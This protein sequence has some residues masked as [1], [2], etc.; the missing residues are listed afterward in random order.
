MLRSF[1]YRIYPNPP[2]AELM[3]KHIGSSRYIYNWGLGI[4][5]LA[6]T[7]GKVNFSRQDLQRELPRMKV[8]HP[9]MKEVNA[10]TLQASLFDLEDAYK[11]FFKGLAN[12]PKFKK[13]FISKQSF[14]IPQDVEVNFETKQV[15]IPKFKEPIKF[16]DA[17]L[18][19][20]KIKTC[21][22]KKS[23]S[24]K[25][26]ISILVEDGKELPAKQ[27]LLSKE[28][29]AAYDLGLIDFLTGP[30]GFKVPNPKF[31]EKSEKK[32]KV[33]Q[34]RLSKKQKGSSNRNKARVKLAKI[35]EKVSNRRKHFL[36]T[37]SSKIVSE[38]Q[39][40]ALETLNIKGMLQNHNLAKAI[41]SASWS[42]F[43]RQTRYK[44]EWAGKYFIQ[45]GRFEP[46]S[47]K[48]SACGLIN[49]DLKL[50]DRIWTC[51]VCGVVHERDPNAVLNIREAGWK[52]LVGLEKSDLKPVEKTSVDERSSDPKKQVFVEA[53]RHEVLCK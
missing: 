17:R 36:H 52:I 47:K 48:C 34:R 28:D 1:E 24:G 44:S 30:D 21:T 46:S 15:C 37:L 19:N 26:F 43:I 23:K 7:R 51:P 9:W 41:Q 6:W 38:N 22:V 3:D 27:P 18:F 35:S 11:R 42:E 31:Y 40:L 12:F 39:G 16:R 53:G 32:L 5:S 2:Q 25:Y 49:K 20:G 8:I 14:S 50:S 13:K 4:K 45:I 33:A 29:L 10:Q